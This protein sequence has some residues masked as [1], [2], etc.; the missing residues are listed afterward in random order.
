LC[1]TLICLITS[2]SQF[3]CGSSKWKDCSA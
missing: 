1:M 2:F 3:R